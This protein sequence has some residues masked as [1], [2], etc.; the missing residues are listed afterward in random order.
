VTDPTPP[1]DLQA[2]FHELA[3]DLTDV[4]TRSQADAT[5]YLRGDHAFAVVSAA[6]AEFRLRPDVAEA[7][8][9]T[10]DVTPSGRGEGWVRL[11]PPVTDQMVMDRAEAWFL[12]AWRTAEP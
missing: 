6:G 9:R 11:E 12:S 8:L 10:P 5:E 2:L 3:E 7:V 1:T 4:S